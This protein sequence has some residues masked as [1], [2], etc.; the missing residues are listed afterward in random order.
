M[1]SQKICIGKAI[2]TARRNKDLTQK[3]LAQ[4]V[5]IHP[6]QIYLYEKE[7]QVPSAKTLLNLINKLGLKP[8]ELLSKDTGESV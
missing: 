3:Q 8:E 7:K 1:L 6:M 2:R 5:N 4:L